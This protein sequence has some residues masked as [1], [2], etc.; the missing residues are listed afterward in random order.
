[1]ALQLEHDVGEFRGRDRQPFTAMID[2]PAL[3]KLTEQIAPRDKNR[4]RAPLTHQRGLF[5]KMWKSGGDQQAIT[6]LAETQ[7]S[8]EAIDSAIPR[9]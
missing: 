4:S 5:A 7:F 8:T 3:T 1:M 9:A 2:L 6:S